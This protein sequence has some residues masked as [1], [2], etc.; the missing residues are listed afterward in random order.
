[1]ECSFNLWQ[2]FGI[3]NLEAVLFDI[4]AAIHIVEL[5]YFEEI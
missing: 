4:H 1:M 2:I 5:I 3:L